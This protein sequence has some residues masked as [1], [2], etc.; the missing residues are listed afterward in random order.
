MGLLQSHSVITTLRSTP[1]GRSG[2]SAGSSPW[3]TRSVQSANCFSIRSVSVR[4]MALT[5][6]D[7]A[8]PEAMR[9]AHASC[10]VA[11][12]PSA[13]GT[14]RVAAVPSAWQPM[15]PF[16]FTVSSHSA[17]LAALPIGNSLLPGIESIEYQ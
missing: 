17:W 3:A 16:V 5:M 12:W 1:C 13:F 4:E 7:I 8:C 6:D 15:Q 9:R 11:K 14:V 10:E 2:R